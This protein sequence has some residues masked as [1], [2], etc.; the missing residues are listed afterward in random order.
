LEYDSPA[1]LAADPASNFSQL[2]KQIEKE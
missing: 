1:R 2:L